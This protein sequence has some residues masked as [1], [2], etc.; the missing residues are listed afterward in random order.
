MV[1]FEDKKKRIRWEQIS[2]FSFRRYDEGRT[3]YTKE[4]LTDFTEPRR[5][6]FKI[7][8]EE[9]TFQFKIINLVRQEKLGN[10]DEFLQGR[11]NQN[12]REAVRI[13]EILL[14]QTDRNKYFSIRYKYF[15]RNQRMIDLGKTKIIRFGSF[16]K[17]RTLGDGRGMASGFHQA[18]CL[19]R[20]GPTLNLNLAFASFYL[21]LNFVEFASKYIRKDITKNLER[22]EIS[23][24][25]ELF[26]N[27]SSKETKTNFFVQ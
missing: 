8:D 14:K 26:D 22:Y 5:V 7:N 12:P 19:T 27:L 13:I 20:S 25:T 2:S 6:S 21:P 23:A 16:S 3:L 18:L 10:I 17:S 11:S 4:L 15:P 24:M 9:K 1:R